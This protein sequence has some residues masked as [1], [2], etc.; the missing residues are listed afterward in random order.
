[1]PD[2]L[3]G[4]SHPVGAT[5]GGDG[6][7]FCVY[8]RH[9]TRIDLLLFDDPGDAAPSHTIRLDTEKHRTYH[10][11]HAFVRGLR[12]G[13][14][15]G[16]RAWG[17]EPTA[18]GL[19]FDA[20]KLLLD[21][22]ALAVA[23]MEGYSRSGAAATGDNTAR[24]MKGVVVDLAAYDWE[25][26][27]PLRRPFA[28]A[29][30]YEMHVGGFTRHP[31]S[32]LARGRRGTFAGVVDKI[33]YLRDL[34]IRSVELM[35]VQQFDAQAS[36]V[37]TNYWGYQPV[38]WF[39]PHRA[40]T[41]TPGLL[42]PVDEFRDM[43]KAL[44]RAGIQVILD[45]VFNHTAE[46][47]R[48]GPTLSLRGLDNPTYYILDGDDADVYVDAT[49]TGNTVNGNE[50]IVRRMILDCL[51]HWVGHMHVDG[52][53]FDLASSLA[54]GEDG[55]P[56][57][58]PPI[59]LDIEADPVLAGTGIIAEPWDAAG[60]YQVA[61]FPGDRWA[62]W[63]GA[64]RDDVR[65]FVKGDT[66]TVGALAD[67]VVG[68]AG[69]FAQP[70][71]DPGRSVNFITAHD[72]FTLADLVSYDVKHNESNGEDGRDGTDANDS[73]N[74]GVEGP[75]D[76]PTVEAL[77]RRQIRNFLTVLLTSQGRPMLLM[78]D[79][80]RRTQGGDN[81]AYAHDDPVSWLDWEGVAVHADLRR[82]TRGLIRLNQGSPLFRGR[83][84]WGEPGGAEITWHGVRRGAPDW[85]EQSHTLAYELRDLASETHLH[86][87]LN[88]YWEPLAFELPEPQRGQ[89]WH[90][91]V[92]TAL[93]PPGD[94]SDPPE[95]LPAGETT[96]RLEARSA[97][98]LVAARG[99]A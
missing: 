2:V 67:R 93:A 48:E 71:R 38:A 42:G 54:R 82:F 6:V 73:W 56:L 47:D 75:S 49:G 7:N 61:R 53:R 12:A 60:L 39:A 8:S 79:E 92:D 50:P 13:Q 31:S 15:Y 91:L 74:C 96:Y 16:Y 46:G 94:Y 19:R 32:G 68:S 11:W 51:R 28:D 98:V 52:F 77:R 20:T 45:V 65:R 89:R 35:P 18:P 25:A 22:Y 76:D 10:W 44:H 40:Y 86:V 64:Y 84:F 30:I 99:P 55:R 85:G 59:L 88:A 37:G 4:A 24:A 69:L 66:R 95:P 5:V 1:V 62:V 58:R 14:L 43:V 70:D 36:P 87:M 72:G 23:N 80:V 78:G 29:V 21:P 9:A 33:P 26:D 34:G 41:A 3:P 90:R 27:A 57:E 97:V 81:N 17:P 63:N 83:R